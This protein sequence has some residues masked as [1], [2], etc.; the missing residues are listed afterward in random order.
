LPIPGQLARIEV[1]PQVKADGTTTVPPITQ[2]QWDKQDD[3]HRIG[4]LLFATKVS[5]TQPS[6]VAPFEITSLLILVATVGVI[7][8]C[9]QD[10]KPRPRSREQIVREAPPVEPTKE[11]ALK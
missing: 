8:L 7:V 2:E 9:K 5:G 10:E 1:K 3:T 6:Y 11:T 4:R